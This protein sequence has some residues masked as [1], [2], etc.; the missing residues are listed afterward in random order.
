MVSHSFLFYTLFAA[1]LLWV[2]LSLR[3]AL[4]V[5]AA[6]A[7][8]AALSLLLADAVAGDT[9]YQ[10]LLLCYPLYWGLSFYALRLLDFLPLPTLPAFARAWIGLIAAL[11][12]L[13]AANW[14]VLVREGRLAY[15]VY[16]ADPAER[17]AR[18]GEALA[19]SGTERVC[20]D[21]HATLMHLALDARDKAVVS[22]LLKVF[23]RCPN[24]SLTAVEAIKPLFDR[25]DEQGLAFL[26]ECGF[27]PSSLVYGGAYSHG[28][29]LA[30]AACEDKPALARL[31]L[32]HDLQ[33]ARSLRYLEA[34][35]KKLEDDGRAE[36]LEVLRQEG[37]F[38]D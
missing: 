27:K 36:M 11:A 38:D 20:G 29:A 33:D 22:E 25:G 23:D 30:Y 19:L 6:N 10:V 21:S 15:A 2:A 1:A 31:L 13:A 18:V 16:F 4:S 17:P 32:R 9:L 12:F 8:W 3:F 34:L 14:G 37:L 26:L 35:K 28:T 5:L 24:A 7:I